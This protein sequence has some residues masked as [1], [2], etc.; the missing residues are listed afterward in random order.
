MNFKKAF[1]FSQFL[2]ITFLVGCTSKVEEKRMPAVFDTRREAE[3]LPKVLIALELIKWVT[4][5]CLV[6]VILLMKIKKTASQAMN[7]TI[8]TRFSNNK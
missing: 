6:K 3:K 4:N 7:I 8:I 2:L 1:I 5:G